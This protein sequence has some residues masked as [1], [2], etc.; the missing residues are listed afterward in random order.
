MGML[1]EKFAKAGLAALV[2]GVSLFSTSCSK[3]EIV[4]HIPEKTVPVSFAGCRLRSS[5]PCGNKRES[6][7]P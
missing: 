1:K 3:K 4:P 6:G 2:A 5:P 7:L